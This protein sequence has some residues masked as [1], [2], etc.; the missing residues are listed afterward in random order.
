M[1]DLISGL[2]R[3]LF[4]AVAAALEENHVC[5]WLRGGQGNRVQ[6]GYQTERSNEFL[7][8]ALAVVDTGTNYPEETGVLCRS[9]DS[10]ALYWLPSQAAAWAKL[11]A[12]QLDC[13]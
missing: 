13:A 3:Q 10:F 11:S 9:E 12:A 1:S 2:P 4:S 5:I 7:V 6:V 8:E